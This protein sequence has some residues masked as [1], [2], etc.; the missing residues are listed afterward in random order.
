MVSYAFFLFACLI[1]PSVYTRYMQEPDLMFLDP[2]TI[3]FYT[4]CVIGFVVGVWFTGWIFPS[5]AVQREVKT[6]ISPM[7][8]LL[9]P[10]S[11]GIIATAVSIFLLIRKFPGILLMLVAQQGGD[12]KGELALDVE[13]NSTFAPLML[14]GIIWWTFWRASQLGLQG[15]RKRL[16]NVLLFL[17]VLS[18]IVSSVI[19]LLRNISMMLICGLVILY[20]MRRSITKQ[21]SAKTLLKL[22]LIFAISVSAFF[23]A[24]SFLRGTASWDEQVR[25]LMGYTAASYNRLAA[26]VNHNLRYP[27]AGRGIYLSYIVTYGHAL[28]AV[29]PLGKAMDPPPML[30]LWSSEFGAVSQAG[31]DG[32]LIWS[33]AFGYIFSELGWFSPLFVFMYGV[34]CRIAWNALK[35]GGGAGIIIYPYFAFCTLTW[36]GTNSMLDPTSEVMFAVALCFI[37]YEAI[38]LKRSRGYSP[39]HHLST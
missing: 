24:F 1:P 30:D 10:L 17:A 36:F 20:M 19:N 27:F 8:F 6:R 18:V 4:L 26:I 34:L 39:A 5:S 31:L 33:G 22:G 14:T 2:A 12:L 32:T 37:A 25:S 23:M 15:T 9:V 3:W 28:N 38:F 16:I 35:T 29:I 21:T 11:I 7:L 13:G